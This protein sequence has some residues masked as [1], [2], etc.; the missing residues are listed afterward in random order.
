MN[1]KHNDKKKEAKFHDVQ[2]QGHFSSNEHK[3]TMSI[4]KHTV[5]QISNIK[6][7]NRELIKKTAK[8]EYS[9]TYNGRKRNWEKQYIKQVYFYLNK[10]YV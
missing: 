7:G 3:T 9:D 1:K 5:L 8:G 4:Q 6:N 2:R 10:F